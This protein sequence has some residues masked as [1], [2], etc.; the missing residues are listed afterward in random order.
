MP[1]MQ[2]AARALASWIY[3]MIV[4]EG[5]SL[6]IGKNSTHAFLL[7]NLPKQLSPLLMHLMTCAPVPATPSGFGDSS[8]TEHPDFS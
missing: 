5:Y 6:S 8:Q 7:I 1:T 3:W 2:C 4:S